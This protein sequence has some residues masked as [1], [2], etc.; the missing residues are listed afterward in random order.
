MAREH[1]RMMRDPRERAR[2]SLANIKCLALDE[3]RRPSCV[4]LLLGA[5]A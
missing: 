5:L 1:R 2:V 3:V 4:P